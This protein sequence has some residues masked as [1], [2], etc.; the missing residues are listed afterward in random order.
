MKKPIVPVALLGALLVLWPA[1]TA[2]VA[3]AADKPPTPAGVLQKVVKNLAKAKG[4]RAKLN[5]VGGFATSA[6]HEVTEVTVRESFEGSIFGDM[7]ESKLPK[8]I[9][10]PKKGAAFIGGGWK[11]I[12]SDRSTVKMVRLFSFPK[13][14]FDKAAL[15]SAKSAKWLEGAPAAAPAAPAKKAEAEAEADTQPKNAKK[16]T[17]AVAKKPGADSAT[18]ADSTASLPR[19]IR[20]ELPPEEALTQLITVQNSNCFGGG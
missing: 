13:E 10:T 4:Y 5:I 3:R 12:L 9:R 7:M 6:D 17:T 16:G 8:T 11:D 18:G 19:F 2:S 1:A 20:V 15:H 14:L